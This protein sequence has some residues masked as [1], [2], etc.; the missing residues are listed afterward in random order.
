[1]LAY[2]WHRPSSWTYRDHARPGGKD[3]AVAVRETR[4][5][6]DADTDTTTDLPD[7]WVPK[8][9]PARHLWPCT[10]ADV[11]AVAEAKRHATRASQERAAANQ[12]EREALLPAATEALTAILGRR[13]ILSEYGPTVAF[14]NADLRALANHL[15]RSTTP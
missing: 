15:E 3:V 13:V 8:V 14:N 6:Y 9:V 7:E 1:V 10:M 2:G 12:A 11:N 5:H 4:R